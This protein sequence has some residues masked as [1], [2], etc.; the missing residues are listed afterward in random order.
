M[1][2]GLPLWSRL[3]LL[4]ASVLLV[5]ACDQPDRSL[6]QF[7]RHTLLEPV[8]CTFDAP[9]VT[10]SALASI[11][12]ETKNRS[13]QVSGSFTLDEGHVA[14][15]LLGCKDAARND[16][17]PGAPTKI[18]CVSEQSV[19]SSSVGITAYAFGGTAKG[20]RGKLTFIPR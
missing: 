8:E 2:H 18:D 12:P 6:G 1:V 9:L 19:H 15:V 10:V 7:C 20:L 16:V 3:G 14:V 5:M 11:N 17:R 13:V 4:L